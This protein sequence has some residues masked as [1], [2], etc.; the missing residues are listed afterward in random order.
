MKTILYLTII[1]LSVSIS[2]NNQTQANTEKSKNKINLI[3]EKITQ[4]ILKF[5]S[6]LPEI[7]GKITS[8]PQAGT[9][10]IK[11]D[12]EKIRIHEGMKLVAKR[13]K[14][15]KSLVGN[16]VLYL[17]Y[18]SENELTAKYTR[19][20]V[21]K[22]EVSD[23]VNTKWYTPTIVIANINNNSDENIELI[24]SITEKMKQNKEINFK[25][26]QKINTIL[27]KISNLPNYGNEMKRLFGIGIDYVLFIN[28]VKGEE[29]NLL[30]ISIVSTY[31]NQSI[32]DINIDIKL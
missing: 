31:T 5:Y 18:N 10:L 13:Q 22:F 30:N 1:L 8:L 24:K 2:A 12:D 15:N 16:G 20:E 6:L 19:S 7:S 3:S 27:A 28:T 26:N 4:N 17:K 25:N 14:S 9:I 32:F 11:F 21:G 23:K 29:N